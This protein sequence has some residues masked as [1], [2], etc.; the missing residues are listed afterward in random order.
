MSELDEIMRVAELNNKKKGNICAS[1][2]TW[3]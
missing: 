2:L 1:V 3:S